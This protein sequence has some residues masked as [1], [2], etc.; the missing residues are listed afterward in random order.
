MYYYENQAIQKGFRFVVGIDEAGRG[1]LA[2]PVVA[3][4]VILKERRFKNKIQDSKQMTPEER[5]T[6]FHEIFEKAYIG[7]GIMN[8]S[9]IDADNILQA[10]FH[11]MNRAVTD[12]VSRLPTEVQRSETFSKDI[13]LI[14]D[15]NRF[16]SEHPFSYQ[17]VIDGDNLCR[18]VS[19][20]SI[21]AKVIR[22][23]ILMVYD[24][25]FPQYGFKQHKGY[26]TAGHRQAIKQHGLSLIHRKTF[27]MDGDSDE[28]ND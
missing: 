7:V 1:P 17:T 22:D 28:R 16:R 3:S 20:A 25:I 23:R 19:C 27:R 26:A 18:S 24:R 14:I 21:I 5:E 15:G 8:E 9:V 4:A 6:T 11:A 10:T 2:G 12:L 13:H